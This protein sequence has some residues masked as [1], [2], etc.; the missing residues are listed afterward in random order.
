MGF[1]MSVAMDCLGL[2]LASISCAHSGFPL[3]CPKWQVIIAAIQSPSRVVI[4]GNI[5]KGE[6]N[7]DVIRSRRNQPVC[8]V[9]PD[10]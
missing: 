3:G 6:N 10:L 5:E 4:L 9:A 2:A 8:S 1:N 7:A